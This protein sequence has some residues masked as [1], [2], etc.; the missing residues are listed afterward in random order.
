MT[1]DRLYVYIYR[2]MGVGGGEF[3]LLLLM[4]TPA[5]YYLTQL[6][7]ENIVQRSEVY[8]I[9]LTYLAAV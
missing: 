6:I 2:Y 9:R 1:R 7:S 4:S 8:Y 5:L 3:S